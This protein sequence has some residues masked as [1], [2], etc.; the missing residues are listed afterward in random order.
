MKYWRKTLDQDR[1]KPK[2]YR[3]SVLK[4]RCKGCRLCIEFCPR[5]VLRESAEFSRK[6]YHPPYASND[7]CINCGLCELICPEFAIRI[8]E[9][10]T[11]G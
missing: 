5:Q 11:D 4:E 1:I 6:G 2:R 3:F 9:E 10:E 8:D 7:K